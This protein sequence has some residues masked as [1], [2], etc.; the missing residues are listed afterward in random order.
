MRRR[1]RLTWTA[2][3]VAPL[4]IGLVACASAA[5]DPPVGPGPAAA[6]AGA[7]LVDAG[8]V[9]GSEP[10]AMDAAVDAAVDA[11]AGCGPFASARDRFVCAGNGTS[12]GKCPDGVSRQEEA[13]PRGCLRAPSGKDAVCM[14]TTTTWSCTG[15]AATEK[16]QS[17][18]YI[19]TAFGCWVDAAGG[20]HGDAGDNCV[21]SCLGDLRRLGLC[22]ATDAGRTC[23]EKLTWFVADAGRFG[24]GAR[25]RVENPANGKAVVA[26]SID[27]GP[28]CSVERVAQGAVLDASGRVSREL[29][30][31]DRGVVD[32]SL[33]HVIEVDAST[34]LGPAGPR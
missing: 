30:G 34:P 20:K 22:A 10:G 24:C 12:R 25:V 1:E 28:A 16:A 7:A 3:S 18:D 29:F 21:P 26:V 19:V 13:C 31:S 5:A 23:E 14:G 11:R 8:E 6:D 27:L 17:G 15:S 32:R 33:V 4:A 9:P 2:R